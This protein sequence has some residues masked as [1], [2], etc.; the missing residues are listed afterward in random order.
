VPIHIYLL[1]FLI[2]KVT[3][4]SRLAQGAFRLQDCSGS[5]IVGG[6]SIFPKCVRLCFPTAVVAELSFAFPYF[7]SLLWPENA[8]TPMGKFALAGPSTNSNSN[9]YN[10]CP[11]NGGK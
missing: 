6:G 4:K 5:D 2:K 7:L 10:L 1:F 9:I 3:K 8:M 11:Q